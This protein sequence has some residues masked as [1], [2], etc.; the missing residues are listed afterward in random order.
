[1]RV[2]RKHLHPHHCARRNTQV[3]AEEIN[4]N[5]RT[6]RM[7]A[8]ARGTPIPAYLKKLNPEICP[9]PI[10]P[11]P[12]PTNFCASRRVTSIQ[13]LPHTLVF[14]RLSSQYALFLVNILS[15][16]LFAYFGRPFQVDNTSGDVPP[17]HLLSFPSTTTH[18]H[19][20]PPL[21]L[22]P[23][24]WYPLQT[25][26]SISLPKFPFLTKKKK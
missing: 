12:P 10:S 18:H 13:H 2:L 8:H 20:P 14:Q 5:A 19:Q 6:V 1:M 22:Q 25:S 24:H 7:Y 23:T 17:P 11:A 26:P 21:S 9:P 3:P 4:A 16:P 15:F